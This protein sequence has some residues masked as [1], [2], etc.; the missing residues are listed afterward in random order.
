MNKY[1]VSCKK[2]KVLSNSHMVNKCPAC[3]IISEAYKKPNLKEAKE[4]V[5]NTSEPKDEPIEDRKDVLNTSEPKD[6]PIKK[7]RKKKQ[8]EE[9]IPSASKSMY[10]RKNIFE[11]DAAIILN[12]NIHPKKNNID[13]IIK[14]MIE[15]LEARLLLDLSVNIKLYH[16][17]FINDLFQ[18]IKFNENPNSPSLNALSDIYK[19]LY[20]IAG[21]NSFDNIEKE[22]DHMMNKFYIEKI[23]EDV[24]TY[25]KKYK[26][27]TSFEGLNLNIVEYLNMFCGNIKNLNINEDYT[28]TSSIIY[29][30][31]KVMEIVIKVYEQLIKMKK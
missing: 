24:K 12:N 18:C 26:N 25:N 3:I 31:I 17:F 20:Y 2:R 29:S 13:D 27:K 1:C 28:I 9:Q 11:E 19:M 14:L 16:I 8:I 5:L 30:N 7:T 23:S 15:K 4:E 22:I 6:E 21:I 10:H